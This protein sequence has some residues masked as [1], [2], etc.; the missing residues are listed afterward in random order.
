MESGSEQKKDFSYEPH[1]GRPTIYEYTE[2]K[3]KF[4]PKDKVMLSDPG[5][6]AQSG[7][8]HVAAYRGNGKYVLANVED[9]TAVNGGA[10]VEEKDLTL[11]E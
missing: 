10:L 1:G 4:C 7:P 9:G 11:L 6:R 3:G 5:S 8:Y 2:K